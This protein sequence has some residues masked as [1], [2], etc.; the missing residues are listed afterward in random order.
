MVQDRATVI[1]L[2]FTRERSKG[3]Y[4]LHTLFLHTLCVCANTHR[5]KVRK[6]RIFLLK[7][8]TSP[9]FRDRQRVKGFL[10]QSNR[11]FDFKEKSVRFVSQT[12]HTATS[13]SVWKRFTNAF[14]RNGAKLRYQSILRKA[15]LSL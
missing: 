6:E 7:K 3:T 5:E 13:K 4:F 9:L 14:M 11:K 8:S 1:Q 10:Q 15:L 2:S 12:Q